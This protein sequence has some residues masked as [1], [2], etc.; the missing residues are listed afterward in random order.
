MAWSLWFHE[1]LTGDKFPIYS[2]RNERGSRALSMRRSVNV[3]YSPRLTNVRITSSFR[4][5]TVD[6]D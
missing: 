1:V 3:R 4:R 5:F 2:R 6:G